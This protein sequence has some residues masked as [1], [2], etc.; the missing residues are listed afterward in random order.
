[1]TAY[2]MPKVGAPRARG[3]GSSRRHQQD[4]NSQDNKPHMMQSKQQ[5]L[6]QARLIFTIGKAVLQ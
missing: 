5:S 3:S 1:M 4:A 2:N 6:K